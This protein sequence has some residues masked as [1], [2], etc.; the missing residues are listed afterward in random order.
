MLSLRRILRG[1]EQSVRSLAV[2]A[3]EPSTVKESTV[4]EVLTRHLLER[5]VNNEALG[6]E[7][8]TRILQLAYMIALP[9]VLMS[10]YLSAAYH[11][12]HA[13]GPRPFWL[14]ISDH[15]VYTV[16]AFVVMGAVTVFEWELLFP[17]LL[18]VFV[19]TSLPISHRRQLL[20]RLLALGIFLTLVLFG[21]NLLGALFFP[22]VADI[23]GMWWRHLFA[24]LATVLMAGTFSAVFFVA[25]QGGLLCLLGRKIF[26]WFSPLVQAA[27]IV[28]LLTI[29]F[30]TPLLSK[31]LQSLLESGAVTVRFFPPFWFLGLYERLLLGSA[32]KPE[33]LPLAAIA[34]IATAG[35][36]V[37]AILTY[38]LAYSRRTRQIIE[39]GG[40]VK[41]HSGLASLFGSLLHTT[42]LRSPQQ[43]A[44]FH[45][46]IQTL[47]RTS[48][49]RL[50][51]SIYAG[52][53]VALSISSLL[54]L[55]VQHG[56]I[57]FGISEWGIRAV[58]PI[59]TF[60]TPISLRTA[61]NAPVNTKGSWIFHVIH[62]DPLP[63]HLQAV[64]RWV[65]LYAGIVATLCIG[66]LVL[67]GTERRNELLLSTQ[68]LMAVGLCVL[69]TDIFFFRF[70]HIPFTASRKPA[71]TDLPVSFVRYVVLFPLFVL[72]I[73]DHEI[74][75]EASLGHSIVTA[76]L[77][78]FAH[79]VIRLLQNSY[80]I[81]QKGRSES[82]EMAII[83]L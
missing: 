26:G 65:V 80:E 69:L 33:F 3:H 38:P 44:V 66:G 48:T 75:I 41:H 56:S 55:H 49:L 47:F 29:L 62:G 21:T 76:M 7:I 51:L 54:L 74:W 42:L 60:L 22:A 6:E 9:E 63:E 20:A 53:G 68:S 45:F 11:Q 78:I 19:L 1:P 61:F 50:Y 83:Q 46:I 58:V 67:A 2:Q 4:F 59:L 57:H 23:K 14:Q 73:V 15:Y 70:R 71:T 28:V 12:P 43:R 8:P 64:H 31:H 82:S 5:F 16:Y 79:G 32:A 17:D 35:V 25:L 77:F 10:L 24:H 81:R 52:V 18:D 13:I 30:L 39:G 40:V 72:W 27:S 37:L 36:L 34:L